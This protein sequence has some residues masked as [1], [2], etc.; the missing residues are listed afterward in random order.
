M[1]GDGA[2]DASAIRL[3]HTGIAL[4]GHGPPAARAAADLVV[5]DDRIETIMDEIVEGRA[6]W[7][8]VR[9]ALAALV[10]GT[11]TRSASC[12]RRRRSPVRHRSGR[13]SSSSS[14]FPPTWC[15]R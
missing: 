9:D 2:N 7:A 5:L 4:G 1:T 6:M 14:T 8:P 10:G 15:R 13:A 12:W 3:A 11:W